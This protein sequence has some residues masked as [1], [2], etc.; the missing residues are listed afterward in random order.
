LTSSGVVNAWNTRRL[1]ASNSRVIRICSSVGSVTVAV[2]LLTTISFL[3]LLELFQHD[4]Q[5]VE[6][7]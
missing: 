6:S 1:G 4:I 3:L 7:L 2:P 5:L